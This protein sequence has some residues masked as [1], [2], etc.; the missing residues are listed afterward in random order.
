VFRITASPRT[1]TYIR[2][3]QQVQ[4]LTFI[5]RPTFAQHPAKTAA[6]G[7]LLSGTTILL[8]YILKPF[9]FEIWN[10]VRNSNSPAESPLQKWQAILRQQYFENLI[11]A[12]Y[13][14]SSNTRINWYQ[15]ADIVDFIAKNTPS[16]AEF[17]KDLW[18]LFGWRAKGVRSPLA[19]YLDPL[20]SGLPK[21]LH[22][23]GY[24]SEQMHH[25][26]GGTTGNTDLIPSH[27]Q[28]NHLYAYCYEL[29]ELF[30]RGQYNW[31]DVHLFNVA[32]KH[33]NDFLRRGRFTVAPNI[34]AML[35]NAEFNSNC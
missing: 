35:D 8:G 12:T 33:R 19:Q 1:Y 14:K 15:F 27:L 31:G 10:R 5:G 18:A 20:N 9:I 28:N 4:G 2:H 25:Y 22:N 13:L 29:Q 30:A 6:I 3:S 21:A 11:T 7:S 16:D 34:R 24:Q 23:T 26:L 32:E 17:R